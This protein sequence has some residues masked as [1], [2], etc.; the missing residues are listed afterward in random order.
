MNELNLLKAAHG[1]EGGVQCRSEEYR[2]GGRRSG[3]D[4]HIGG[5][6]YHEEIHDPS[7]YSLWSVAIV[8]QNPPI[9]ISCQGSSTPA[10][11]VVPPR[12][13]PGSPRK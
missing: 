5:G 2:R 7:F 9:A 8:P 11:I 13:L 4:L 10:H 3:Y 1:A 12:N 6:I